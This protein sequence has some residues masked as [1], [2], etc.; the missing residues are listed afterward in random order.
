MEGTGPGSIG[1]VIVGEQD[2]GLAAAGRP[3]RRPPVF[4]A[5]GNAGQVFRGLEVG[6]E[7]K[8]RIRAFVDVAIRVPPLF[9]MDSLLARWNGVPSD[10]AAKG[11]N[12]SDSAGAEVEQATLE[13]GI[14]AMLWFLVYATLFFFSSVVF[15]LESR[16]LL[17]VYLFLASSGVLLW[18]YVCNH[19]FVK[20][21]IALTDQH[22]NVLYEC[23]TLNSSVLTKTLANYVLQVLLGII[24]SF[25]AQGGHNTLGS[26][27]S[28]SR[29]FCLWIIFIG[30]TFF[31]LFSPFLSNS[32]LAWTPAISFLAAHI[33]LLYGL[34]VF[35]QPAMQYLHETAF[36][37]KQVIAGEGIFFLLKAQWRR[38]Q[39]PRVL[40]LFWL[41]RMAEHASVL[42]AERHADGQLGSWLAL[43]AQLPQVATQLLVR[44]CETTLSVMGMTSLVS[45]AS[46]YI[47]LAVKLFLQMDDADE[48]HMGMVSAILFFV[49]AMQSGLTG[50]EP[51]KRLNRLY[52]NGCLLMTATLHFFH[53]MINSLLQ[54]LGASLNLP[55]ERHVRALLVSAFLIVFPIF[56][57]Y[58]AWTRHPLSTWLLALSCFS[59]EVVFKVIVSLIVYVLFLIDARLDSS[60]ELFDDYVYTVRAFGACMELLFGTFLLLNGAWIF[61]FEQGGTIRA[62]TI[63]FHAYF[64]VWTQAKQGWANSVR[65][66]EAGRRLAELRRA[67][68]EQL[69]NLND[70]CAIC[71]HEMDSAVVTEC[72]HFYHVNCLRRWLF[73][74]NHCPLCHTDFDTRR[75][76]EQISPVIGHHDRP[77]GAPRALF[78]PPE[79]EEENHMHMD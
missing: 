12:S 28:T 1:G 20:S 66:R 22:S 38:L 29:L 14:N 39:V 16:Q 44:G 68:P 67:T 32:F 7:W 71:H 48:R 45:V 61:F 2:A 78:V 6:T 72:E 59:T 58:V 46:H 8:A 49:L 15:L 42:L 10:S 55:R 31:S 69:E 65:R 26:G 57:M 25:S 51:E 33:V 79:P 18:S 52:Q 36:W 73:M 3:V 17:R 62:F 40:R 21:A 34:R 37:T 74:Q 50:M 76:R 63:L 24:F 75:R 53:S 60:W 19:E 41:S 27:Y 9:V 56:F 30:P 4:P 35:L 11:S 64:N 13:A 77:E 23:L 70:V 54:M 43:G 47:S 5:A